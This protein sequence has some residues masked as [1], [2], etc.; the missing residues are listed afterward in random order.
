[1]AGKWVRATTTFSVSPRAKS[2]VLT[3]LASEKS[4]AADLYIDN[5]TLDLA[6]ASHE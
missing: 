2:I 5:I 4:N 1:M 6:G 3:L